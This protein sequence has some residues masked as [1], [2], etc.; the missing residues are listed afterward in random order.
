MPKT[1]GDSAVLWDDKQLAAA[2]RFKIG[3]ERGERR[4]DARDIVAWLSTCLD[5]LSQDD[6]EFAKE[7]ISERLDDSIKRLNKIL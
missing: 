6:Y 1:T 4:K 5:V 3:Q 7:V 2:W